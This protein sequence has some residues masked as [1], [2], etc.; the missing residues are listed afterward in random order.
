MVWPPARDYERLK[1]VSV[2]KEGDGALLYT[3]YVNRPLADFVVIAAYA[4]GVT[5]NQ[6]SFLGF[7]MSL[8][9]MAG[10]VFLPVGLGT[11]LVCVLVLLAAYVLDSADGRLARATGTASAYGEWVDH[12]LDMI[13]IVLMH[14]LCAILLVRA[15]AL[16]AWGIAAIALM[17][18]VSTVGQFFSTLLREK[19]IK[20]AGGTNSP[21]DPPAAWRKICRNAVLLPFDYGIFCLAFVLLPWPATF[22]AFYLLWAVT[23]FVR[24][25]GS[26]KRSRDILLRLEHQRQQKKQHRL[27]RV[28]HEEGLEL[29][30]DE[31]EDA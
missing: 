26:F 30:G 17:G 19:L 31:V 2:G 14:G 23:S 28:M 29:R 6:L 20:L 24:L 13:K 3:R 5:P 1:L 15:D 10:L 18:M 12:S 27:R 7:A 4:L 9:G 21:P 11:C 16:P 8:A 25:V 22:S